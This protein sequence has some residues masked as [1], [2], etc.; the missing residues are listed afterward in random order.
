MPVQKVVSG[1]QTGVDRAALDVAKELGCERG[2]WCPKGRLAEDGRIPD[3]YP[4]SE[5]ETTNYT[6][7]TEL[8]V[9]DSDG[10]LILTVGPPTGGTAYTITCAQRLQKPY[11]IIDLSQETAPDRAQYWLEEQGIIVLNVAG[12]RQ[13]QSSVGY[14]LAYQFLLTLL[15][16]A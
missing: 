3:N 8:N 2:G 10:T 9:R 4:L 11:C 6:E 13:S 12:P 16:P 14:V 5:T 15:A 1:G 7:R